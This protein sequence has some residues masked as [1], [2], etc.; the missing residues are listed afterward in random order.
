MKTLY[1]GT[2]SN[3]WDS[4]RTEG[5]VPG[6]SRGG[7]AWAQSRKMALV[8]Q[9]SKRAPSVFVTD[10]QEVAI[11]FALYAFE[12][13]GGKPVIVKIDVPE[14]IFETFAKDDL[15]KPTD[16]SRAYMAPRIDPAYISGVRYVGIA[17]FLSLLVDSKKAA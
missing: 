13:V 12:E 11:Q 14:D 4:I 17:D 2:S 1:H 7:D 9:A 3:N 15:Y 8:E 10:D 5:L 6:K 16:D